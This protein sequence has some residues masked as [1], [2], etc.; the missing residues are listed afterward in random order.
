[1]QE[2][3]YKRVVSPGGKVS[4]QPVTAAEET[5]TVL[6]LSEPQCLTAA[7]ALGVTLLMIFERNIPSHK[8]VAR[9]IAAVKA[10]VLDLY[11]GTGEAIDDETADLIFKA[12]DGTMKSLA[13]DV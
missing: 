12:W 9:K 5:K 8:L 1:M 13:G 11:K 2:Q 7:G 10:A 6:N 4:Y 3:H